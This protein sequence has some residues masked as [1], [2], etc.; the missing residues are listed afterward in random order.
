MR[1]TI[2]ISFLA[3]REIWSPF[4]SLCSCGMLITMFTSIYALLMSPWVICIGLLILGGILLMFW[5]YYRKNYEQSPCRVRPHVPPDSNNAAAQ[6]TSATSDQIAPKPEEQQAEDRAQHL[7]KLYQ[8][9]TMANQ[10]IEIFLYKAYHNFLGPIATI[11]GVCN[12]AVLKGQKEYADSYFSQINQV[13]DNMQVMLEK[14]LEVSVIHDRSLALEPLQLEPFLVDYQKKQT[15]TKRSIQAH[16]HLSFL[17]TAQVYADSYLLSVAIEK[18]I[19]SA[20]RFR[21]T[22]AH[23]LAEIFV[24]YHETPDYDVIR[25]KEYDLALPNDT[26]DN[27]FKMFHRSTFEPDD[28]GLGF[29]AARYAV[30]RMGGDIAIESGAGYVTFCIR[31]PKFKTPDSSNLNAFFS[32]QN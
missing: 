14:L 24:K 7:G 25:L 29:Y 15:Q 2:F 22:R 19:S 13:A 12:V 21:P 17:D 32:R 18:I 3:A 11:R 23:T 16:F 31:L 5:I 9:L 10:D 1:T 20:H 4:L 27:L 28:H 26:I 30:R 6:P 8:E